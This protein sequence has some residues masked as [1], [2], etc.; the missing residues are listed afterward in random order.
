M[1]GQKMHAGTG[2]GK[3]TRDLHANAETQ[4]FA[5]K[6]SIQARGSD[7]LCMRIESVQWVAFETDGRQTDQVLKKEL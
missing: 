6:E 4:V 5:G 7:L 3:G 2:N 1:P